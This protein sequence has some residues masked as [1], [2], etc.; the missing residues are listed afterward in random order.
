MALFMYAWNE[1]GAL[2]RPKGITKYSKS[3]Y[4]VVK[5]VFHSSPSLI[6]SLLNADIISGWVKYLA[7]ESWAS[8]CGGQT[9]YQLEKISEELLLALQGYKGDQS[10]G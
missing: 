6:L 8:V 2:Q 7:L 9:T 1:A 3:P 5:A 4:L 10:L